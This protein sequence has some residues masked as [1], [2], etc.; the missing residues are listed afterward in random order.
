M[1]DRYR[2]IESS[3]EGTLREK[4]SRFIA[5]A[6]HASDEREAKDRIALIAR[7]HHDSRHVCYAYV[8]GPGMEI[9]RINDAGEPAGTAGAP[10]LRAIQQHGLTNVL[11]VVVRYFGGTLLGKA[12]LVR[13]YSDAARA[14]LEAATIREEIVRDPI[15]FICPI[16]RFDWLKVE[17]RR[18]DGLLT[19]SSFSDDCRG[20]AW[21]PRNLVANAIANWRL[22]GIE[23][24][25]H[26]PK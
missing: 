26:Q 2:T 5:T 8:L 1:T 14:A 11:V 21:I 9:H 19:G 18:I 16:S 15:A 4:A 25:A 13:A 10:I 20:I 7:T 17:L 3:G 23:A 22:H 12:G 24:E 6:M